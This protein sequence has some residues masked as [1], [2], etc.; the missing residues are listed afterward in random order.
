VTAAEQGNPTITAIEGLR[1]GHYTDREAATGCTVVLCEGGA[2]AA[3]DVRGGAP[4]T[5]ETDLLRPEN[6]VQLVQAILLSGGS[7]FGLAAA[8][9]VVQYLAERGIGFQTRQAA[10]PIVPSAALYDLG[11]GRPDVRPDYRAGRA[12]CEAATAAPVEQ[13]SVGAGTGA[14]VAH[15]RGPAASL[16]GGLGS[17]VRRLRSGC[18]V[19][20]LVAVNAFGDVVEPRTGRTLA[21]PRLPDGAMANTVSLIEELADRQPSQAQ[22][23]TLAVVATDATLE[24]SELLRVAQMAQS[25]LSRAIRPIHTSLDGDVIFALSTRSNP[26]VLPTIVGVIAAEVL[27]EAVVQAVTTATSLAGR[28]A[29]C[30]LA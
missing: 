3:V 22:H 19:G 17:S 5:R 11:L 20:A 27:A 14:S 23:T 30:D 2:T 9:G 6:T 7:A 18:L 26:R 25:G 10:V 12:A 1:V 8:D 16:K 24:R 15:L 4:A 13:G 28:T 21:G 29:L